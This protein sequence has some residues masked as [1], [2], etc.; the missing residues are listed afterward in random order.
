MEIEVTKNFLICTLHRCCYSDQI[1]EDEMGKHPERKE[2]RINA[3]KIL[4]DKE[5]SIW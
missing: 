4:V 5:G 1:R 3:Y 2:E